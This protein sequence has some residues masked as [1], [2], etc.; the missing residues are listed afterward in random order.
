MA[1]PV[2]RPGHLRWGPAGPG[3]HIECAAIAGNRLGLLGVADGTPID[4]QGG[5]SDL[6]FPHHECSAAHAEVLSGVSTFRRAL[7]ARRD[8]RP[9]RR[10]DVQV[11]RQPGIRVDA[12]ASRASTRWRS[13]WRCSPATTVRTG[14]G[15]MD[16]STEAGT[17]LA[18]GNARRRA[19]GRPAD[20]V[21]DE[22]RAA[23]ADD[24]DTPAALALLDAW[25]ADET[26]DGSVRRACSR[27]AARDHL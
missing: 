8:D 2:S 23:L 14:S 15:T 16:C 4:V 11:A 27:C 19:S 5:G 6:I 13:G 26:L 18:A 25:A 24:L 22:L 10:E 12:A 3:W 20:Q 1:D 17:R 9:R 21:V 7:H